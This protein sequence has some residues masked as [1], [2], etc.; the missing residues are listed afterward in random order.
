MRAAIV[1]SLSTLLLLTMASAS[2]AAPGTAY[3]SGAPAPVYKSDAPSTPQ[4]G[5]SVSADGAATHSI[6]VAVPPGRDGAQP[7]APS[8]TIPA[9][10]CAGE[11]R[12]GGRCSSK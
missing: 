2:L 10:R 9:R 5:E 8:N 4:D 3:N 12:R 11:L 6:R 1:S 7:T